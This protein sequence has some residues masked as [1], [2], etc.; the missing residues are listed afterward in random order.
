[1]IPEILRHVGPGPLLDWTRHFIGLGVFTGLYRSLKP[2]DG[3]VSRRLNPEL[4][5]N[6]KRALE[7]LEYGSGSDYAP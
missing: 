2:L 3:L 6:W 1:M 5:Y 4:R 7:A